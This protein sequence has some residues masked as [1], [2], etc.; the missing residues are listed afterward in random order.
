MSDLRKERIGITHA[1]RM[2][3]VTVTELKHA[4]QTD[5]PLKGH[6][7]P[8][9]LARGQGT[10]GTQMSF[11]LGEIMDLAEQMYRK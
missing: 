3:K 7:P 8:K 5:T 2:L 10:S 4:I 1:A 6:A 9:P 11:T